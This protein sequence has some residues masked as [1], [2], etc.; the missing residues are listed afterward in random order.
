MNPLKAKYQSLAP[1]GEVLFD[2]V[3]LAQAWKKAH[4]YIRRHNW[5]ADTLELDCSAVDLDNKLGE[6]AAALSDGTYQ[7]SP[8]RVVPAPKNAAWVFDPSLPGGWG[9]KNKDDPGVL[10]PLAHLGIR[11]QDRCDGAHAL[12][13]GLH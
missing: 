4:T 6:W 10:R 3:I 1:R 12:P 9:P 8:C 7:P 11:E 5:Y 2:T 13:G